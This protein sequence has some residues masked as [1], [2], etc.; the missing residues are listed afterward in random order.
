MYK[1]SRFRVLLTPFSTRT[2]NNRAI[3]TI[4]RSAADK[5]RP[6]ADAFISK[7]D[8]VQ[9]LILEHSFV[10]NSSSSPSYSTVMSS[11]MS[12]L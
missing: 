6:F 11:E 8:S 9:S 2:Y 3:I 1:C 5:Y 7:Q 4:E 12:V 10:E